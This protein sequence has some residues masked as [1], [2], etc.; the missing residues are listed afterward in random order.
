MAPVRSSY[1]AGVPQLQ[2]RLTARLEQRDRLS[3]FPRCCSSRARAQMPLRRWSAATGPGVAALGR[4]KSAVCSAAWVP[5]LAVKGV[6]VSGLRV[7]LMS[8]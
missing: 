7:R 4:A 1:P 2:R 8:V 6:W 5:E 3:I